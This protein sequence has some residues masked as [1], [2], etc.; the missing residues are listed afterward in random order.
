MLLRK[1][2]YNFHTSTDFEI[3]KK[4]KEKNCYLALDMD[5]EESEYMS[6]DPVQYQLPDNE[7]INIGPEKFRAP[8]LL[9]DPSLVGKECDGI[10]DCLGNAI[11]DSDLDLRKVLS[12]N[13]I[14]AGGSTKLQN[15]GDRLFSSMES[16][17]PDVK[18]KIYCPKS[19]LTSAWTGGAILAS[20]ESFDRKWISK[21]EYKDAGPRALLKC[22]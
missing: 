18:F 5:N 10:D 2:G 12:T 6:N 3:V 8:E 20:M 7:V 17:L 1:G 13:I 4:I 15:F 11:L 22:K 21:K 9:F 14:V 19:R 16:M